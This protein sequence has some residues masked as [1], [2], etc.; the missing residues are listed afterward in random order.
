M[1]LLKLAVS[2]AILLLCLAAVTLWRSSARE[3]AA[4]AAYPPDGDFVTLDGARLH[5]VTKG[6]GPDL[7]LIHGASGSLRDFSFDLIDRLAAEYRVIAVDRPGLGHSDPIADMSLAGQAR[8][9]KAAVATLGVTDPIVLGQSY[10][11]SVALAWAVDG[12]P[13]ALV[14]VSAPSMPWPGKLDI[15]YRLTSNPVGRAVIIPL[16]SAFVPQSYVSAATRAVFAPDP[17]PD[18]YE[19]WLGTELTLRRATLSANVQQVNAL[20]AELITMEPRYPGLTL[21]VELVHGDQDTVVPLA[22][23][24]LPL[25]ELLPNVALTVIP[26]AG[27]M[28]HHSHPDVIIAAIARAALR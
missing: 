26:G 3:A 16:A 27:H 8:A 10:G 5:Y 21:P 20:R 24:S 1:T 11:G 22:I 4:N 9:I 28:P 2:A 18:G 12:G 13:R 6:S 25:S 14:L 15:W 19:A 23:H 7:V 17:L